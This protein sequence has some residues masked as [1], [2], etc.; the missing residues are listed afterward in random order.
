MATKILDLVGEMAITQYADYELELNEIDLDLNN[1]LARASLR[2]TF[3]STAAIDF[4]VGLI[5]LLPPAKLKLV[6]TRAQTALLVPGTYVWGV[7]LKS[8]DPDS[9]VI[10]LVEGKAI[11]K[12]SAVRGFL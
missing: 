5:T 7:L 12:P 9:L 10:T 3:N 4:T 11:V 2:R 8:P 6:L 1:Y